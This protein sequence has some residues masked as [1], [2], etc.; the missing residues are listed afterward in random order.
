V[1]K[2]ILKAKQ[3]AKISKR[4]QIIVAVSKKGLSQFMLG[5]AK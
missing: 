2:E 1:L 3:A 5:N 4:L